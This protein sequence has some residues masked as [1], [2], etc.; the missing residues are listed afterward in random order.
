M[1]FTGPPVTPTQALGHKLAQRRAELGLSQPQLAKRAQVSLRTVGIMENSPAERTTRVT[2]G[3][4][5][6]LRVLDI[7]PDQVQRAY[8]GEITWEEAVPP[9]HP[10]ERRLV[11]TPMPAS[12]G[13]SAEEVGAL[14]TDILTAAPATIKSI[15]ILLD[16]NR[17]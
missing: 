13:L 11:A 12:S 6:V 5:R 2:G 14:V 8:L 7:D 10:D 15:Q 4:V 9:V 16:A 17:T 1:R 3:L